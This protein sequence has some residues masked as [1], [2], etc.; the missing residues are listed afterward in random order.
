MA[1]SDTKM[2]LYTQSYIQRSQ[3]INNKSPLQYTKYILINYI[4]A[5]VFVFNTP[6][7]DS[8]QLHLTLIFGKKGA[9]IIRTEQKYIKNMHHFKKTAEIYCK[10]QLLG[11]K[12]KQVKRSKITAVMKLKDACKIQNRPVNIKAQC[13]IKGH[14]M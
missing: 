10:I 1:F 14:Y 3:V 11:N 7:W 8:V 12:N 13:V 6:I 4:N 2:L 9:E 5:R